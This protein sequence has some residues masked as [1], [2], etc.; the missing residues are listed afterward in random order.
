MPY[1]TLTRRERYFDRNVIEAR[2]LPH[3]KKRV[4]SP[5]DLVLPR[6]DRPR[7]DA[8]FQLDRQSA[9]DALDHAGGP[10]L[11]PQLGIAM[12]VMGVPHVL[13]LDVLPEETAFGHQY[14]RRLHAADEFVAREDN[15][16][17]VHRGLPD[18]RQARIHVNLNVRR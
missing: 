17:L 6:D 7:R 12:I 11:V 8:L 13:R 10:A 1:A 9:S 2:L 3:E 16:V 14:T 15:R 5:R 18:P 4:R